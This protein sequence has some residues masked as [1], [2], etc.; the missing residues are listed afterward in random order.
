[1]HSAGLFQYITFPV[2]TAFKLFGTF[3]LAFFEAVHL[4]NSVQRVRHDRTYCIPGWVDTEYFKP[5]MDKAESFSVLFVGRHR[6]E[7]GWETFLEVCR[8]LKHRG[9]PFEFECTGSGEAFVRGLGLIKN[10]MPEVY[11]A[12]HVVVYPSTADTFGLVIAE[13]LAC[14]TPIITT[15][16][17]AHRQLEL[18]LFYASTVKGCVEKVLL[19]YEIWKRKPSLYRRICS[20]GRTKVKKY[21]IEKIFPKMETMLKEVS[22]I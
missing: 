17:S 7:K 5:H 6:K 2:Y 4:Q 20:E 8:T 22:E 21:D 16:T 11:S 13:S 19:I 1:M 10:E 9:Y 15:P 3:D 14:G 18:P 12:A